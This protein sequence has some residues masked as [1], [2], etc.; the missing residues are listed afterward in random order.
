MLAT[1]DSQQSLIILK[2]KIDSFSNSLKNE[3]IFL[4]IK[5][6]KK[7]LSNQQQKQLIDIQIENLINAGLTN[8]EISWCDS[9]N[10]MSYLS[11]IKKKFPN[12][13][14]GS[15]SIINKKSIDE[16]IEIGLAYSM[17]RYW[18]KDLHNYA[19]SKNHILIPG[20]KNMKDLQEAINSDCKIIK[21]YPIKEID[22]LIKITNYKNISFIA[23]GGLCIKDLE[24]YKSLGYKS[25]I[26]GEMAFKNNDIDPL[27]YK[28]LKEK[29][30]LNKTSINRLN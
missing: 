13:F 15:A 20:I 24:L 5:S 2:E 14:L 4:L 19:K 11:E 25:I 30:D 9:Q 8:L 7:F 29:S 17:M 27:I 21:I 22:N 3:S 6:N 1:S 26:I 28:W 16:S 10:W 12:L 23:A 18:D